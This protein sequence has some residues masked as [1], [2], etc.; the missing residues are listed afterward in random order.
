MSWASKEGSSAPLGATWVAAEQAYNLALY[1]ENAE[2]VTL[3]LYS[4]KNLVNPA[5]S[6]RFDQFTNKTGPVWHARIQ[7]RDIG[8]AEF[9]GYSV[10]GPSPGGTSQ[11]HA[12]RPEKILLD[13][14][15]RE[16]FFPA[17]YDR[18]AAIGPGS[19]AG[20]LLWVSSV[21]TR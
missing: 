21:T 15:A 6:Y 9:Y 12:F 18:G 7:K 5:F 17:S 13:P 19:N 16:V 4:A 10:A 8:D 3:L 2:R 20:K 14:Y 1:S 11:Y